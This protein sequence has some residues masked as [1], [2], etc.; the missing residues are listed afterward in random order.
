MTRG[1]Q[2]SAG[3]RQRE[4]VHK[5]SVIGLTIGAMVAALGLIYIPSASAVHDLDTFEL[6]KDVTNDVTR[7]KLATLN[8]N[9]NASATSLVVCRLAG[10]AD[11]TLNT[12]LFID[13]EQV[14]FLSA[15]AAGGGGCPAGTTKRTW[16]VQRAQNATTAASHSSGAAVVR[17]EAALAGDDWDDVFAAIN[18]GDDKCLDLGADECAFVPDPT[19][20]TYFTTGGSKDDLDIPSWRHGGNSVPDADEIRNAYAA[21]YTHEG[22]EI[23]YFGADR[24]AVNGSKDFGFW[25]T[26]EAVGL[27]GNGTF[28]GEH[29]GPTDGLDGI[30]NTADDT[31]GDILILGTFTGGGAVTTIRVFEW[32]GTGGDA[33][34]NGTVAGPTGAFGDCVPGSSNDEGCGTV[35]NLTITVPWAYQGKS[36]AA[37]KTILSGGMVE[38]GINLTEL[39]LQGCFSTFVAE[40]RSSPSVDATLKDFALGEFEACDSDLTTTPSDDAG[41]ALTDT[42]DPANGLPDIEIGTGS[43]GV[44]VTDSA[45]LVVNGTTAWEG[46]LDFYLCGPIDDPD[47]CDSGGALISSHNV[48]NTD[49]QPFVSDS[50]NLTSV[51]RYCWRGEFTSDTDG[52][53]NATDSSAGECFEVKPVTPSLDTNAV[54]SEGNAQTADVPFGNAVYDK[55]VLGGTANQPGTNGPEATY[56]TIN[57]TDG[58]AADGS[59]TFTLYGPGDCTTVASGTGDN[60]ETGVAVTGDGSYFS[61]GFTPDSPGDF[62]WVASYSG[63]SPNTNGT[64]HNTACNDTDEDVTVQQLQPTMDTEQEFVPNDSATITVGAGA[65]DLAGSVVFKL[66]VDDTD[67]SE[68]PAYTSTAQ[69]VSDTDDAGDTS[70]SDTVSSDNAVAYKV[71][72]TTFSWVAEFTSTTNAHQDVT[73]GCGNETSSITV[74]N[75]VQQPAAP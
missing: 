10:F 53:P 13:N 30:P 1:R 5:R 21:K 41:V 15:G 31:S 50:A 63:S 22:D 71:N 38:G 37:A 9:I 48:S 47:T 52:V 32:V 20:E 46:T 60:P 57:A 33:T 16:T 12:I 18:G 6:D 45:D 68:T 42:D 26:H 65:G 51:G 67:C 19:G 44:D 66:Y 72:G 3:T 69:A 23:L 75:G 62:H 73:S 56:P 39:G 29:T 74:D 54:D 11:P 28:S 8:S 25:F 59:I 17:R 35:N 55:A 40:T 14:K 49:T 27:N 34:S 64:D 36:V 24:E 58:A 2:G 61:S 4:R 70:L 7:T 43:A